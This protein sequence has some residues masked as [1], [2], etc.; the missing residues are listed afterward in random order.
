MKVE[1]SFT[2]ARAA[3][4]L[5][6]RTEKPVAG[7][8]GSQRPWRHGSVREPGA[9]GP[10]E[11]A[12]HVLDHRGS[13][14]DGAFEGPASQRRIAGVT[15]GTGPSPDEDVAPGS[16]G[17]PRE[18][19]G[20]MAAEERSGF[21]WTACESSVGEGPSGADH[22]ASCLRPV[23]WREQRSVLAGLGVKQP[24]RRHAVK[25]RRTKPTLDGGP[26]PATITGNRRGR[27]HWRRT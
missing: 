14:R 27:T 23:G 6:R 2:A 12:N 4:G 18:L 17:G 7:Q 22:P 5:S 26:A 21:G 1:V 13:R 8:Q 15:V 20:R 24:V 10:D 19:H 16:E 3:A 25:G 9:G 11:K